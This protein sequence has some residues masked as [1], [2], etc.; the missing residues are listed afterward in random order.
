MPGL[1]KKRFVALMVDFLIISLLLWVLVAVIYPVIALLN[2]FALFIIWIPIAAVLIVAYFTYFEG[3]YSTT[4]G[5][6]VMKLKIRAQEGK[7]T[8][9]KALIRN[10]SKILWIPLVF[11]V[12]IG[13]ARGK[14]R[15][16]YL[17][18]LAKTEVI[19]TGE[20][21]RSQTNLEQSTS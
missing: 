19:K 14:P 11:D 21:E 17:D 20:V 3:K 9:R 5:K 15:E 12:I 7:M 13:F 16:R 4:P 18:R 1:W 6:S 2:L 8:Y 10:L